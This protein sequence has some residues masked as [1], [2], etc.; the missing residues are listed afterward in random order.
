VPKGV[1]VAGS[2]DITTS[3]QPTSPVT[4]DIPVPAASFTDLPTD[5]DASVLVL[6][7]PAIGDWE[8]LAGRLDRG[9][10][11]VTVETPSL[12]PLLALLPST[13]ELRALVADIVNG[14]FGGANF[15]TS[16]PSCAGENQIR[17]AGY[18]ITS[19][20]T[21]L[22]RWC[23][24]T[25]SDGTPELQIVLNRSYPVVAFLGKN[26]KAHDLTGGTLPVALAQ[27]A[28]KSFGR[29]GE[30]TLSPGSTTRI[31]INL[32][33][34]A[35]TSLHAEFDGFA[36]SLVSLQVAAE[37]LA[38]IAGYVRFGRAAAVG[39]EEAMQAIDAGTCV[40]K[41]LDLANAPSDA[42]RV[43]AMVSAC[44]RPEYFL[45]SSA[46]V[47]LVA[48]AQVVALI[49][50]VL[51]YVESSGRALWDQ[52]R[53]RSSYDIT[54][55]RDGLSPRLIDNWARHSTS[56][57]IRADGNGDLLERTYTPC[58]TAPDCTYTAKLAITAGAGDTATITYSNVIY[59]DN[60]QQ[61]MQL[62]A[63]QH[64]EL[65][66]YF[67]LNGEKVSARIDGAGRLILTPIGTFASRSKIDQ[68]GNTYCGK[69][70]MPG[71]NFECGA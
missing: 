20:T 34:G 4:V 60:N 15:R 66:P 40:P 18:S 21:D 45:Q 7:K 43:G 9:R 12:S 47:A 2:V 58:G 6:H 23:L 10:G 52:V 5:V 54:I 31:G 61:P 11:V 14:F 62:T 41:L 39:A 69:A 26:M 22:L 42:S 59:L 50:G 30:V 63:A 24:G 49:G 37:V 68:A 70:T 57:T 38:Q 55:R 19:T 33:S 51:A 53:G 25:A 27:L 32:A 1:P 17:A 35:S 28:T 8:P 29:P 46:K 3:A 65:D 44:L 67:P 16:P 36:Q 64:T 48:L 71:Q 13:T 56:L